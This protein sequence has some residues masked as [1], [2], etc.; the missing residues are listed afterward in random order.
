MITVTT[1]TRPEN[2][3]ERVREIRKELS[4]RRQVMQRSKNYMIQRWNLNMISMGGIYGGGWKPNSSWKEGSSQA[5]MGNTGALISYFNTANAAG[6]VTQGS[7]AWTFQDDSS[8]FSVTHS[9]FGKKPNPLGKSHA[10]IPRRQI[11]GLNAQDEKHIVRLI[12]VW[13]QEKVV[14]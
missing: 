4:N 14:F 9:E 6:R 7:V 13:I 8:Q 12:D 10:P 1:S 3:A 5:M 11:W 2:P